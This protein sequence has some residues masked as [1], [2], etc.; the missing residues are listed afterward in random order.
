MQDH[1]AMPG[2]GSQGEIDDSPK[3][4]SKVFIIIIITKRSL[5]QR[6]AEAS[7]EA[8]EHVESELS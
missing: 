8:E 6:D 2:Q 4:I 7:A 3:G 1:P 5:V